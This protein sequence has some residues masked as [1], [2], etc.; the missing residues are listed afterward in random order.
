LKEKEAALDPAAAEKL[1][2][3]DEAAKKRD[4]FNE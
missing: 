3:A 4:E 2:A 1:K